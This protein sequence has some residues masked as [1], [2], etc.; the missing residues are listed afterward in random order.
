MIEE[1]TIRQTAAEATRAVPSAQQ[2]STVGARNG[3]ERKPMISWAALLQEAVTKPGYIHEAYSRF[4]NFRL[5]IR[6]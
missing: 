6:F 5:V 4:H 2:G 1:I 3:A